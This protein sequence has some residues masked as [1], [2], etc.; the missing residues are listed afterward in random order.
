[1]IFNNTKNINI[2]PDFMITIKE[3]TV[4]AGCCVYGYDG[5]ACVY[6]ASVF[7]SIHTFF[8]FPNGYRF[9]GWYI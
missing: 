2:L 3:F 6:I 7:N 8:N 9:N 5:C 4:L 1:M